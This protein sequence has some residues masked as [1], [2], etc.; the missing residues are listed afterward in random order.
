MN[1][2][3]KPL[4]VPEKLSLTANLTAGLNIVS[5]KYFISTLFYFN[6]QPKLL[7]VYSFIFAYSINMHY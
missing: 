6:E 1:K 5:I 7:Y 2:D 3:L 4:S